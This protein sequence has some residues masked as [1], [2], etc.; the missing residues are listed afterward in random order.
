V[1]L[2]E[3]NPAFGRPVKFKGVAY[4]RDGTSKT[5]LSNHPDK[6]RQI[7]SRHVDWSAKICELATL[8]DLDEAAIAR[9]ARNSRPS[10]QRRLQQWTAGAT[11]LS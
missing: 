2:F 4:I 11:P 5:L 3:I 9:P 7:W 10:F 1:V 6:E 8:A